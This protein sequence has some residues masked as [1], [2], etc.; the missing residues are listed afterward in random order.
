ME[1]CEIMFFPPTPNPI[2][3][4]ITLTC[5]DVPE[6]R[7]WLLHALKLEQQKTVKLKIQ[8][9]IHAIIKSRKCV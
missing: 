8:I 9:K 6:E 5:I 3:S 1:E 7:S 2:E 4:T